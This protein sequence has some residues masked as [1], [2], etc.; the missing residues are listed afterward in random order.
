MIVTA[1]IWTLVK[2]LMITMTTM[3]A[4][5]TTIVM[6]T[7]RTTRSL[8]IRDPRGRRTRKKLIVE[9]SS[10]LVTEMLIKMSS[11]PSTIMD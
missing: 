1:M 7:A 2:G 9:F 4:V 11:S 8:K 5:G 3:M 10:L 6:L